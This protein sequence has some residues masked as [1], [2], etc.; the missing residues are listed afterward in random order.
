MGWLANSGNS[1]SPIPKR[2]AKPQMATGYNQGYQQPAYGQQPQPIYHQQPGYA[3]TCP[4]G[5]NQQPVAQ[6]QPVIHQQPV[7]QQQMGKPPYSYLYSCPP[8]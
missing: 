7:Y 6:Q 5:Y 4:A 1:G 3:P 2:Q 8:K